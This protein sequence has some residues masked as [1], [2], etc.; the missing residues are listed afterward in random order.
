LEG[1][2]KASP[3]GLSP[4][5]QLDAIYHTL[6]PLLE[7]AVRIWNDDIIPA[8]KEEG[9]IIHTYET[10]SRSRNIILEIILSRNISSPYPSCI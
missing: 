3:D 1:V 4:G 8:L 7:E 2:V 6:V 5:E 9:I 10:L